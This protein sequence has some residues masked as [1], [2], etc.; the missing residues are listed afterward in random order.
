MGS[1]REVMA[2]V[3]LDYVRT[4]ATLMPTPGMR[5]TTCSGACP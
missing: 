1:S 5:I 2:A 3:V 4:R